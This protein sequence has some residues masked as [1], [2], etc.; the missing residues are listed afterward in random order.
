M[1]HLRNLAILAVSL[2]VFAVTSVAE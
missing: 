1:R 2:T